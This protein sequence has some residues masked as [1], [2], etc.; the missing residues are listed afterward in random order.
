VEDA[1]DG[2]HIVVRFVE[3]RV[4]KSP[5]QLSPIALVDNPVQF[6]V[7]ENALNTGV[8][9]AQKLLAQTE[10]LAFIPAIA[11]GDVVLGFRCATNNSAAMAAPNP[12][13]DFL[14]GKSRGWVL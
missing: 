2:D 3:D 12:A 14:P 13:L 7:A 10:S 8:D 4:G 11:F 6:G 5:H 9:T 1:I